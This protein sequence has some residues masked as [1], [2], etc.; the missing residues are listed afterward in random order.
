MKKSKHTIIILLIFVI[1]AFIL[2][3]NCR[4]KSADPNIVL[5]VIDTLRAD[6][7][8]FYG[9]D[10]NTA[11]FLSKIASQGIVFENAFSA[12]S[13]TAPATASIFTSL[14]PI[15]HGVIRGFWSSKNRKVEFHRIPEKIKTIPEVLQE[16]GYKTYGI[17]VNI[18]ICKEQGFTQG[19]DRFKLFRYGQEE[20]SNPHLKEW[21]KEINA[22]KKSFIYI[23]YNDPHQPYH[24][25]R[26]WYK[27]RKNKRADIISR[28]DSE[29][30]Y[31]DQKI[32]DIFD[33][34]SWDKNTL[35]IVT[36]DHGEGF[37]EHKQMGH[38]NT[39]YS[40]VL[41][42]PFIIYFPE[43]DRVHKRI[44]S[45]V[46]TMDILPTMKDYLGIE[47]T[48][49]QEGI[50]LI[51]LIRGKIEDDNK[52]FFFPYLRTQ[53]DMTLLLR[54]TIWK[55]WK[56]I[57]SNKNT[58]EL[59][60]LKDDPGEKVNLSPMNKDMIKRLFSKYSEFEKSCKKFKRESKK[61]KLDAEKIKE[62]KTLGYVE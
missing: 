8:P 62:L 18:N 4:R 15:Q 27:E 23:H 52:R 28:Y 33:F 41:R 61:T 16:K 31:V 49:I 54:G 60:N 53:K 58:Q 35:L 55:E 39:L 24:K 12:S 11:P 26:P 9:Y 50:S 13:W 1:P 59:Y 40:E 10:K 43:K 46:S 20:R 17:A 30:N 36:A 29:I 32:K 14:Y 47:D 21:A 19:F 57:F 37:M 6:H 34:F 44:K 2:Q 48:E 3:I 25:R 45:N 7:L 42:V 38:S 51:P 5:I 22:Q 56:Y